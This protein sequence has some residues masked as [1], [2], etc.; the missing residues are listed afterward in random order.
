MKFKVQISA[1]AKI[2]FEWIIKAENKERAALEALLS[3]VNDSD[4]PGSFWFDAH[5]WAIHSIEEVSEED[6]NGEVSAR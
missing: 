4:L 1:D 5:N 3:T 6:E 2:Y